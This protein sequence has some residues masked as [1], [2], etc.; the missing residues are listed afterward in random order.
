[1]TDKV[2]FFPDSYLRDMELLCKEHAVAKGKERPETVPLPDVLTMAQAF[3]AWHHGQVE[4]AGGVVPWLKGQRQMGYGR[5]EQTNRAYR[6]ALDFVIE[7]DS[8]G[9]KP[10]EVKG[11]F[12]V[13]IPAESRV[14]GKKT[15]TKE[16]V[17]EI[18]NTQ[19]P[20]KW[21]KIT[22][23]SRSRMATIKGAG[24]LNAVAELLPNAL[25]WASQDEWWSNQKIG[26]ENFIGHGATPKGHLLLFAE[27]GAELAQE[28]PVKPKRPEH[29]DFHPPQPDG[30]LFPKHHSFDDEDDFKRREAGARIFYSEYS[31][32]LA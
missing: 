4:S 23:L 15:V 13:E 21:T 3:G 31:Q 6:K 25:R 2:Y 8:E 10:N 29:P 26:F 11:Q 5:V 12:A 18:Y 9:L 24:G 17:I 1:M 16:E 19:K 14:T 7:V 27:K 32:E 22:N 20:E 28:K 30:H